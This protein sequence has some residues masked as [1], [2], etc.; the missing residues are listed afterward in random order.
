MV[1]V[2]TLHHCFIT[3]KCGKVS[4][5]AWTR[6]YIRNGCSIQ[7]STNIGIFPSIEVAVVG[8]NAPPD[9]HTCAPD[10]RDLSHSE[11]APWKSPDP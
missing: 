5:S 7:W 9:K 11:T 10:E 8:V 1:T 2:R 6:V 4:S 3:C